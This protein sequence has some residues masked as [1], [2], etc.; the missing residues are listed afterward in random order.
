MKLPCIL[1][2][3]DGTIALRG[4]R[5][6]HDHDSSMEDAPNWPIINLL[7]TFIISAYRPHILI[8]GRDE[9]YR[10][11]TEYWLATHNIL[12]HRHGLF[13][14]PTGDNR[15]DEVVKE[16]LYRQHIEPHFEVQYVFD[17]RNKVVAMWRRLGLTCLQVADGDF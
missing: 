13:M 14:R 10:D 1:I 6:P 2:D 11:V 15:P 17:D 9:K 5:S 12:S 8:S 4:D 7:N 3:I 16:A